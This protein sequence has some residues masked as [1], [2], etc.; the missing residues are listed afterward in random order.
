MKWAWNSESDGTWEC[1]GMRKGSLGVFGGGRV[2]LDD[3]GNAFSVGAELDGLETGTGPDGV[4][5][6]E[7]DGLGKLGFAEVDEEF[8]DKG[9]GDGFGHLTADVHGG[10]IVEAR[11]L[12]GVLADELG[13]LVIKASGV[14]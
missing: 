11:D 5:A 14:G 3:L 10:L 6:D 7:M 2:E 8:L 4:R 12:K 13:G 1:G 9:V